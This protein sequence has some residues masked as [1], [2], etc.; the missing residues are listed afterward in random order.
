MS[1]HTPVAKAVVIAACT[2]AIALLI[3]GMGVNSTWAGSDQ[4][5]GVT[6]PPTTHVKP[7][8]R[9]PRPTLMCGG[10]R[11]KCTTN[12][13]CCQGYSCVGINE[14]ECGR[15]SDIRLKHDIVLLGRYD[16]G[17]GFYRFSY[18]GSDK[19]Y[20]GV[21]AQEVQSVMPEAVVRGGDGYLRVYYER[22]GLKF[23][24][25]DEWVASGKIIPA[26]AA[27]SRQ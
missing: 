25:W 19:G 5:A 11:A 8:S 20:V 14:K 26:I 13:D 1:N 22:L 2:L 16:N 10:D 21:M 24:T 7:A 17:L 15:T 9:A 18:N 3:I 12:A 4:P 6:S 27:S 23:Q